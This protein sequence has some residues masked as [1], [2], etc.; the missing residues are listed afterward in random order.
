MGHP[1]LLICHWPALEEKV[2]TLLGK[3]PSS[4]EDVD[5]VNDWPHTSDSLAHVCV[6]STQ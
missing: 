3:L 5:A 2:G 1:S 4:S 6:H